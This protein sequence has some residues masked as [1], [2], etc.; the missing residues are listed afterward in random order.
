MTKEMKDQDG[1]L[2]KVEEYIRFH[3]A[4][5][6]RNEATEKVA[7]TYRPKSRIRMRNVNALSLLKDEDLTPSYN[8]FVFVTLVHVHS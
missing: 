7:T 2:Q 3:G 6:L 8:F 5:R 1:V 4:E